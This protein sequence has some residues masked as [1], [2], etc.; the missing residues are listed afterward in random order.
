VRLKVAAIDS[1]EW[2]SLTDDMK[3]REGFYRTVPAW[4]TATAYLKGAFVT[5]GGNTYRCDIAHT[6]GV[7]AT[8]LAA[9]KWILTNAVYSITITGLTQAEAW[10]YLKVWCEA[11]KGADKVLVFDDFVVSDVPVRL[12]RAMKSDCWQFEIRGNMAI[13]SIALAESE[14][15]LNA[16]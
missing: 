1:N 2:D 16:E 15:E 4:I 8:D 13:S 10:V 5:Q 11:D 7:F 12:A 6:S 9:L 14:K 3:E